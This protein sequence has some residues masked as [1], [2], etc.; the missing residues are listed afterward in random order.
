MPG[1]ERCFF[2]SLCCILYGHIRLALEKRVIVLHISQDHNSNETLK[3]FTHG[4]ACD[5]MIVTMLGETLR[6]TFDFFNV[7]EPHLV[8]NHKKKRK[9]LVK[10]GFCDTPPYVPLKLKW[11]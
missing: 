2:H 11:N 9:K 7:E 4:V 1:A 3:R 6:I 10:V 5:L 8:T